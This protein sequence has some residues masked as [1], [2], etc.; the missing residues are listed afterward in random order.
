[1]ALLFAVPLGVFWLEV[2]GIGHY[3]GS[4]YPPGQG[5]YIMM[6]AAGHVA[7]VLLF[8][9]VALGPN[10]RSIARWLGVP[11]LLRVHMSL[12]LT[13]LAFALLHPVLFLWA[14]TLRAERFEP[15]K[16]FFPPT[17]DYYHNRLFL[18]A[19]GLYLLVVA[20]GAGAYGPRIAPRLWRR[21]HMLN[22][23]VFIA[24]W[25]HAVSI[26]SETRHP[27]LIA[28]Y[29]AMLGAVVF[30]AVRRVRRAWTGH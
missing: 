23:G 9:Q 28:L 22:Y 5:A 4:A 26:G 17:G 7:L 10:V 30:L 24:L 13:T 29:G 18:G 14:R 25:Y 11:S 1:M 15:L 27:V 19:V 21:V 16:V 6:R 2:G 8:I 12:G 20:I 3:F